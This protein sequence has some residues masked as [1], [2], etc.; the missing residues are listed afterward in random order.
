MGQYH[1]KSYTWL[2]WQAHGSFSTAWFDDKDYQRDFKRNIQPSPRSRNVGL[3]YEPMFYF[4]RVGLP[5]SSQVDSADQNL[6][7]R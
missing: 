7:R 6:L 1:D 3:F 4:E 5:Q 2:P